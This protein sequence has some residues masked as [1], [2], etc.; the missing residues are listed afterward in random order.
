MTLHATKGLEYP[1]VFDVNAARGTGNRRDAVRIA[2]DPSGD[3]ISVAVGDYRSEA[4]EDDAAREREETKRLLY[5]AL[6]RARDRLYL[7]TPMKD[8]RVQPGRG[9]L[10]DVWPPSLL[11]TFVAGSAG[12]D[13]VNWD[14]PAGSV[15]RFRVVKPHPDAIAAGRRQL[16]L[17]VP[18]SDFEPVTDST[19]VRT[20]VAAVVAAEPLFVE[21]GS[22]RS[23]S[24]RS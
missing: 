3:A 8:G 2:G 6:T 10:A 5:V 23:L 9:S 15:H 11:D 4:D 16:P 19:P 18:E 17:A 13:H 12:A 1:V 22:A 14:G 20:S 21:Y 24:R 7:S